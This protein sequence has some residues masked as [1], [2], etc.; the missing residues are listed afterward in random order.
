MMKASSTWKS[1]RRLDS[2]LKPVRRAIQNASLSPRQLLTSRGIG[3]DPHS[4]G[5]ALYTLVVFTSEINY[6]SLLHYV[7]LRYLLLVL[8][9]Y[10]FK[11]YYFLQMQ[12]NYRYL[13]FVTIS[14]SIT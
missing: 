5:I 10:Y 12:L 4:P 14:R 9:L 8:T 11:K 6:S 7:R 2:V 3:M 1:W 13:V